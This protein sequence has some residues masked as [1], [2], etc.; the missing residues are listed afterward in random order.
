MKKADIKYRRKNYT[1]IRENSVGCGDCVFNN[2]YKIAAGQK[3]ADTS[4]CQTHCRIDRTRNH[5]KLIK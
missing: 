5:W 2:Q 1:I 4:F 3:V